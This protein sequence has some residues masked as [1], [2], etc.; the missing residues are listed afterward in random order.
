MRLLN[1]FVET[2]RSEGVLDAL[3]RSFRYPAKRLSRFCQSSLP[4]A[5]EQRK[6]CDGL[7]VKEIQENLMVL[8]LKDEGISRELVLTGVHEANSTAEIK[9]ELKEGMMIVEVGANI[10][11]YTLIEARKIG[12]TGHIIAFEPSPRNMHLLRTNIAL[13]KVD[14]RIEIIQKG[15][16]ARSGR[17]T[18]YLTNKG[19]TSSFIKRDDQNGITISQAVDV[20]I[21]SLDDFFAA[22]PPRKIDLVR[23][24]VEGYEL[25]VI[26]GMRKL[27]ASP[28]A[29]GALFIEVHS[30]LLHRRGTTARNFIENLAGF[31]YGVSKSFYRGRSDIAVDSTKALLGHELLEKGYWETFFK[32]SAVPAG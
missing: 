6:S 20:D 8:D 23:M 32:K 25:E 12:P 7:L 5:L 13:N 3:A 21:I 27:M 15:I 18:F 1:L 10:G 19:N 4:L 22:R 2:T 26:E 11:Y 30:E 14:E 28:E 31:G 16:G 9:K 24:D 29:P 17:S